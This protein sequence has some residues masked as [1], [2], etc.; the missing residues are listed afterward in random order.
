MFHLLFSP[1][2]F[3][4]FFLRLY[5]NTFTSSH[6]SHHTVS[7]CVIS[8]RP[9]NNNI[10]AEHYYSCVA[11]A[12]AAWA[13]PHLVPLRGSRAGG[14]CCRSCSGSPGTWGAAAT[15]RWAVCTWGWA[16]GGRRRRRPAT[17][18]CG[19]GRSVV[20]IPYKLLNDTGFVWKKCFHDS[21]D[22]PLY[23]YLWKR[24]PHERIIEV[25]GQN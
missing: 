23:G 13:W 19:G 15:S 11:A 3:F 4:L 16:P 18:A 24:S 10:K 21:S 1:F 22:I 9:S 12:V 6:T 2:Y 25:K 17:K 5:Q 20:F 14:C 8:R 7:V